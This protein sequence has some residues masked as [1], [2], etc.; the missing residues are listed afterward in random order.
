MDARKHAHQR[1]AMSEDANWGQP[2]EC[3]PD[4]RIDHEADGDNYSPNAFDE[5]AECH[6]GRQRDVQIGR[7]KRAKNKLLRDKG[8]L[9]A[10]S[11][12]VSQ[13]QDV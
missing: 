7:N 4:A 2:D 1:Q 8:Y 6:Y 5:Q 3:E 9:P 13:A 12:I 10:S 11:G